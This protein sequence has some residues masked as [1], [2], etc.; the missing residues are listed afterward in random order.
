[1]S[2]Q[3][4][5]AAVEE[6]DILLPQNCDMHKWSVVACDQFTSDKAYW[7][8]IDGLVGDAPSALRLIL[9]ECYLGEPNVA[10]RE[11]EIEKNMRDYVARKLFCAVQSFILVKRTFGNGNVRTGLVA[12]VD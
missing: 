8:N 5:H 12:K 2:T 6:P 4:K 3:N 7:Q 10:E 11:R 9:P 1:M